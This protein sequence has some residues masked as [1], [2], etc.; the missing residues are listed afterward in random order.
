MESEEVFKEKLVCLDF[1]L[2]T[3]RCLRHGIFFF[4]F[5]SGRISFIS[6]VHFCSGFMSYVVCVGER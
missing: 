6:A 2:K 1:V 5:F 3:Y 4:F